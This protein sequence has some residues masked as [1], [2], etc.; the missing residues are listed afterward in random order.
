MAKE[1][2]NNTFTITLADDTQ[3]SGLELNGNNFVSKTELTEEMFKGK[4]GKVTITGDAD[5]DTAGLIGEHHNMEL[6]QIAHYTQAVHG[7]DDGWYFVLRDIPEAERKWLQ[8]RG[9]TD[10][11]AMMTGVEL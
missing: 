4:L 8:L 6:V 10:Y 2:R 9:D 7:C 5:A 1:T 3:I 11:I